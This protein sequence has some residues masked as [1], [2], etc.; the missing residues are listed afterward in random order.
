MR[1]LRR[2]ARHALRAG[3]QS[4]AQDARPQPG[5]D[6]HHEAEVRERYSPN[7]TFVVG[8][9]GRCWG[10]PRHDGIVVSCRA[11]QQSMQQLP[12]EHS[13][14]WFS[15]S[16]SQSRRFRRRGG[17][18]ITTAGSNRARRLRHRHTTRVVPAT[19]Q[20]CERRG[21][22][23]PLRRSLQNSIQ[24]VIRRARGAKINSPSTAVAV[25]SARLDFH[26]SGLCSVR[27]VFV[28]SFVHFSC[29]AAATTSAQSEIKSPPPPPPPRSPHL[30]HF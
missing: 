21:A 2:G 15:S 29:M 1:H 23:D 19:F 3:P 13:L 18:I 27:K 14:C 9:T 6:R 24:P 28:R 12:F 8:D 30:S 10:A 11:R 7:V 16:S 5:R 26:P 17:K 22:V 25:G 4:R 20:F